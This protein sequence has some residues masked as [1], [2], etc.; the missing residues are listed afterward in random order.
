M[1]SND[2]NMIY[3]LLLRDCSEKIP[4]AVMA[5]TLTGLNKEVKILAGIAE[6]IM[7][8]VS[9]TN[10][11]IQLIVKGKPVPVDAQPGVPLIIRNEQGIWRVFANSIIY[12]ELCTLH[13]IIPLMCVRSC[14]FARA[15]ND[16]FSV[17]CFF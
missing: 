7:T 5:K 9:A 11:K 4:V 16:K 1:K 8:P 14:H 2:C 15:L 17:Q 3:H 12:F 10:M 6:M 13:Y